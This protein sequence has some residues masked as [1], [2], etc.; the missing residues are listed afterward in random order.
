M[1]FFYYF[2]LCCTVNLVNLQH[3]M[4]SFMTQPQNNMLIY[5]T[6]HHW[7]KVRMWKQSSLRT[8]QKCVV[9]KPLTQRPSHRSCYETT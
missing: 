9:V 1:I 4:V 3:V 2:N 6:N 8:V 7:D 5:S